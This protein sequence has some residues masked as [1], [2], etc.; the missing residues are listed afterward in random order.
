MTNIHIAVQESRPSTNAL[1]SR[2]IDQLVQ[3]IRTAI[4]PLQSGLVGIEPPPN[5][6]ICIGKVCKAKIDGVLVPCVALIPNTVICLA[7]IGGGVNR[8][9]ESV[10][11]SGK[12]QRYTRGVS[13]NG[14]TLQCLVIPLSDFCESVDEDVSRIINLVR[15]TIASGRYY[16]I[17]AKPDR[18][19]VTVTIDVSAFASG[20]L[21]GIIE[22]RKELE[23][24]IE[25]V[26]LRD[27]PEPRASGRRFGVA[28]RLQTT[29]AQHDLDELLKRRREVIT[30]TGRRLVELDAVIDRVSAI[31]GLGRV[32][33]ATGCQSGD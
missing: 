24:R 13:F 33:P 14:V 29:F 5:D 32:S 26:F 1:F 19:K 27:E 30:Q 28:E 17:P 20:D 8:R 23:R 7:G 12:G 22:D 31:V 2:E 10:L 4:E 15:A 25:R 18:A 21:A 3:H 11:V 16:L 6:P 9:L